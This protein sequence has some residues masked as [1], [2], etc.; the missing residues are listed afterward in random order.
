MSGKEEPEGL[1]GPPFMLA[2]GG[3]GKF[4]QDN[5]KHLAGTLSHS[6]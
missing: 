1:L 4:D 3:I 5:K 2:V 6:L